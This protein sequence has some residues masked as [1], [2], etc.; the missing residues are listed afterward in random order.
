MHGIF[1]DTETTG[2]NPN[3]HVVIDI[4]FKVYDLSSGE[5]KATYSTIV[6]QPHEIWDLKDPISV[7]VNGF[8]WEKVS[9]GK[10]IQ[11]VRQEI[12]ELLCSLNLERDNSAFICQ[13]PSFDRVFFT[14]IIDITEQEKLHW[15]Y[16]WL[17]LASMYWAMLVSQANKKNVSIPTHVSLSKN[18]IAKAY[19]LP[20]ESDPHLA[21]NGVTH[22]IE[23]YEAVL[24]LKLE[25]NLGRR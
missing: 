13:N 6:K 12:I 24:G 5:L 15:P 20:P 10:E 1:L 11:V 9:S 16:H 17:D 7:V 14:Q 18:N 22:L 8:T 3:K 19:N 4:A 2:L 21:I 23:C 25:K